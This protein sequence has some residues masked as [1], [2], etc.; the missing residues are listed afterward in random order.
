MES[1]VH[2]IEWHPYPDFE[3]LQTIGQPECP[4]RPLRMTGQNLT[5]RGRIVEWSKDASSLPLLLFCT[6]TKSGIVP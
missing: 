5:F 2:G 3:I 4:G 1:G 6:V